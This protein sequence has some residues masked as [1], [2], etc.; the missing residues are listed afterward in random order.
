M[1]LLVGRPTATGYAAGLALFAIGQAVRF[2]ASGYIQ[3]TYELAT[4]GP[5]AWVRNPLYV[6]SFVIAC[7]YCSMAG[8]WIVWVVFIPLF[9]AVHGS[10]VMWEEKF[11]LSQFGE[12]YTQYCARVPR[13]LP[14]L[15]GKGTAKGGKISIE[16][17]K[18]NKEHKRFLGT[19]AVAIVFLVKLL[20]LR[21]H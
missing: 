11:L 19:V 2:W 18:D 7:G 1:L 14:H 6:G 9:F 4:S 8:G 20:V 17:I 3:K 13:W 16:Q 5:F 10:A 21:G 12:P 15:P